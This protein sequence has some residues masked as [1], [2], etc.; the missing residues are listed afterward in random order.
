[1][2]GAKD[3]IAVAAEDAL[4]GPGPRGKNRCRRSGSSEEHRGRR[5]LMRQVDD[6]ERAEGWAKGWRG[7]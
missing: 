3:E 7:G 2:M 6:E 4:S 5:P 1:M